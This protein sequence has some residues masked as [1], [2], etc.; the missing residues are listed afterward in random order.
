[1]ALDIDEGSSLLIGSL[2]DADLPK[3]A[4][5]IESICLEAATAFAFERSLNKIK[6]TWEEREFR[7]AKHV[8]LSGREV[9]KNRLG[10]WH[11]LF[12]CDRYYQICKTTWS[13]QLRK[14]L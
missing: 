6:K 4:D 11:C 14:F 9:Y 10:F 1:M 8:S 2:L 5:M 12:I 3:Y 7:I 13:Q